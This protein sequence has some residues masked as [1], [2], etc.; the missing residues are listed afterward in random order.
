MTTINTDSTGVVAIIAHHEKSGARPASLRLSCPVKLLK[1]GRIAPGDETLDAKGKVIK[2]PCHFAN[3]VKHS[4][5]SVIVNFDYEGNVNRQRTREGEAA[6]F[7]T[8]ANWFEHVTRA[9]VAHRKTAERYIFVRVLDNLAAPFF[10]AGEAD[11]ARIERAAL[12]PY[13]PADDLTDIERAQA[14]LGLK[15]GNVKQALAKEITPITFK[16]ANVREI[17]I[18]GF[19]YAIAPSVEPVTVS[20]PA[21]TTTKPA[22]AGVPV[23]A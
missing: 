9:V 4:H 20:A 1:F 21:I 10:T 17:V 18:D 16:L 19:T 7:Q 5:L 15:V 23:S 22:P 3:V 6:D 8:E 2:D 11:A 12:V 14:G 13:L